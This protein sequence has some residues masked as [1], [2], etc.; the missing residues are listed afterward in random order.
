MSAFVSKKYSYKKGVLNR[1]VSAQTVGEV[2][3]GIEAQGDEITPQAFL[4]ASRSEESPTHNIFTWDDSVASE[5]WRFHEAQTIINSVEYEI[6]PVKQE[7]SEVE[8]EI[9]KSETVAKSTAFVNVN[10]KKFGTRAHYV[11]LET[12]MSNVTFRNQVL[13]NA[14]A[15]LNSFKNKYSRLSELAEVFT[16]INHVE[17]N[18]E[19][20][21]QE[22]GA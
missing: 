1:G 12:A 15:E 4:D 19:M 6:I 21:R 8:V 9:V 20:S 22:K 16:A 18:Y 10:P 13:E 11:P 5:K 7:I 3:E 17:I 2:L 14:L